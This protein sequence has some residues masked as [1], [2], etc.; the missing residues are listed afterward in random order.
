MILTRS[1]TTYFLLKILGRELK[2]VF[3]KLRTRFSQTEVM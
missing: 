1:S 2:S 3:H